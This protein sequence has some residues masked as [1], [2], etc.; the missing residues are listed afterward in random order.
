MRKLMLKEVNLKKNL[1]LIKF[2]GTKWQ[3]LAFKPDLLNSK[4]YLL[5]HPA[6]WFKILFIQLV[7]FFFYPSK[8]F[9]SY[10]IYSLGDFCRSKVKT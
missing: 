5:N 4:D 1:N 6:I 10:L 3:V 9:C 7:V 8:D 2:H